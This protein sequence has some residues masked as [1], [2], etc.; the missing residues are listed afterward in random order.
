MAKERFE[1]RAPAILKKVLQLHLELVVELS[2]TRCL[3]AAINMM[4]KTGRFW[5]V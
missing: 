3:L 4:S 2:I 1:T 5:Q